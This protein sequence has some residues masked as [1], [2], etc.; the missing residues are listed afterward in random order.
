VG[1]VDPATPNAFLDAGASLPLTGP[2]LAVGAMA[3][4]ATALGPAYSTV[5]NAGSLIAGTYSLHGP[6]G[7]QVGGFD[8]SVLFPGSFNATNWNSITLID[9]TQP[10]TF[11]WT[12]TS[13]DQ[14]TIVV[15]TAVVANGTQH[16]STLN[17]TVPGA[18]G[19][20]TIP[21]AALATLSPVAA[22][23]ASFGSMSLQGITVRG[24]FTAN[25]T[26]G[27]QTDIGTFQGGIGVAKNVAVQ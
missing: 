5:L 19:T 23:G 1:G 17:C 13:I 24:T 9:R 11:T 15:S 16:I 22:T 2:G 3:K 12:G 10:L 20:Y 25:L 6:G 7:T 27:G 14:V 26:A 4:V 21:T 8:T 18:P